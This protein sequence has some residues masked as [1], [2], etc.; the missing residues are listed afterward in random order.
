[1]GITR[2]QKIVHKITVDEGHTVVQEGE[3]GTDMFIVSQG[4]VKLVRH[5][6][7]GVEL[8]PRLL[9][10]GDSFGEEILSGLEERYTYTVVAQEKVSLYS[11]EESDFQQLFEH[12][13]DIKD[14]VVK[15]ATA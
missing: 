8:P 13:P 6:D 14:Q 12:M 2:L 15:N 1:M 10:S 9:S 5:D 7:V 11:I 3:S 4:L